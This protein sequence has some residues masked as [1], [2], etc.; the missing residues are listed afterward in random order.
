VKQ[1]REILSAMLCR[2]RRAAKK[3]LAHHI[4]TNYGRLKNLGDAL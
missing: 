1:H 3:A 4:R 2:D